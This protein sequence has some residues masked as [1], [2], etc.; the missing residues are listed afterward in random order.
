MTVGVGEDREKLKKTLL[1]LLESD[2][3][4]RYAVM[5][6]L[7]FKEVLER[8]TRVEEILARIE[9]RQQRLEER[10]AVL[11]ER[12]QRLEERQLRLEEMFARLEERQQKLEERFAQLEERFAKIEE[13]Q[14]KLEER[15]AQLE[16]RFAKIEERFAR[17]EERQQKLEERQQ[18]LEERFAE[19]EEKFL[20]IEEEMKETRRVVYTVAHR[21]GVIT[22]TSFREA[23]KYVLAEVL[24]VAE[25]EKLVMRDEE[26]VVYGYPAEVE[27]D[28]VVRDR[29]HIIVEVKSRVDAGDV[30]VLARKAVLYEKKRKVKPRAVI[31]GGF[32]TSRAYEAAGRLGV[33]IRPYLKEV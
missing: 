22:E 29:E 11:E 8:I 2:A 28:L 12:Q 33:E 6:L 30:A 23:M 9:E 4:F 7:G 21:F 19:L 3:E 5:G 16:E 27:I 13:R 1:E 31:L 18:K 10:F 25:V 14:Q 26:G 24:G 15:F 17:I 32:I 20:R